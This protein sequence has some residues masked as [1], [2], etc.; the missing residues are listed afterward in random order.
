[1]PL[2]D[3]PGL[4]RVFRRLRDHG[5]ATTYELAEKCHVVDRHAL[6]SLH[7][8]HE[9]GLAHIT[10]WRKQFGGGA[11][12]RPHFAVWVC[13]PGAHAPKP[14][15]ETAIAVQRRRTERLRKQYGKNTPRILRSRSNG[16]ADVIVVDGETVYRRAAPRGRAV[17]T[18]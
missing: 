11:R 12:G 6:W 1:M 5:P 17:A 4:C 3:A 18:V 10:A 8:L 16:G 14:P 2:N 13:G 9:V 15:P 7:R